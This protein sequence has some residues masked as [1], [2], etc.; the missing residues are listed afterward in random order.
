MDAIERVLALLEGVSPEARERALKA[1]SAV[2]A[3]ITSDMRQWQPSP[4]VSGPLLHAIREVL[5]EWPRGPE[6]R[7]RAALTDAI[8]GM[9][10]QQ[11]RQLYRPVVELPRVEL[12]PS[13]TSPTIEDAAAA[14]DYARLKLYS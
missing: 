9:S 2:Q 7:Q 8:T 1:L 3:S 11:W 4:G 14:A 12:P 13:K 10:L 5:I 6:E